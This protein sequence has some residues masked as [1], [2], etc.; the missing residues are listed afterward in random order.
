MLIG[1]LALA[2]C[3]HCPGLPQLVNRGPVA[4]VRRVS[5]LHRS[6]FPLDRAARVTKR[7]GKLAA[8]ISW[9]VPQLFAGI[10]GGSLR[11]RYS[12]PFAYCFCL[13]LSPSSTM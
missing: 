9:R 6:L 3:V 1:D 4:L 13:R 5:G 7:A 11:F 8:H 2:G 10:F 12:L